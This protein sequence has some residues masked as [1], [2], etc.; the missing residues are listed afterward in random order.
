MLKED[1]R[2]AKGIQ[3]I[4]ALG[5][6]RLVQNRVTSTKFINSVETFLT[7]LIPNNKDRSFHIL[8]KVRIYR[9]LSSIFGRFPS[10]L[11]WGVP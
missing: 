1:K 9:N 11:A 3:N 10:Y 8:N 2:P 6:I 5:F 7:W 4:V